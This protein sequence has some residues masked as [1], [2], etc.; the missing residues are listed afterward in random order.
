MSS[1]DHAI[2]CHRLITRS[3]EL[4]SVNALQYLLCSRTQWIQKHW[5]CW[6]QMLVWRLERQ[7]QE[8]QTRKRRARL[9]LQN[10]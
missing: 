8:L 5:H 9:T 6:P 2:I 3:V 4:K 10:R 7:T 1:A